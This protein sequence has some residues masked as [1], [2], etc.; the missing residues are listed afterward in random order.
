MEL[1]NKT[2]Y[3]LLIIGLFHFLAMSANTNILKSGLSQNR[4]KLNLKIKKVEQV[5]RVTGTP[6]QGDN[7][8]SPNNTT[9]MYDVGGTDLG[10]VWEMEKG[11][12]GIFMGDTYGKGFIPDQDDPATFGDNWR[13]NVLAFSKD[14]DLRDGITI[15]AMSVDEKGYAQELIPGGKDKSGNGDWTSIP[16]AA[17]RANNI[18]YVHYFNMKNWTGWVTN[19]SGLYKSTDN[20]QTW[21]ECPD[22]YFTSDSNFGQ[23]G[24]FKK[25]GYVYMVGTET[26]R[27]SN[28]RLVRFKEKDI[29]KQYLYE[30]WNKDKNKWIR[31]DESEATNLFEDTVGEL[32][33]AYNTKYKCWIMAYFCGKRYEISL[34]CA[35]ELTGE[36]SEPLTLATGRQY[37]QLY[38]SFIHP[39]SL[40]GDE[41]YFL[42]SMWRPYNIFLMK[43]ELTTEN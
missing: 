34:R 13:C 10:I 6:V 26:G 18:D 41:L 42:M 21:S 39:A 3:S 19:Y 11:K 12:Y 33:I 24:Y 5:A 9:D 36:W 20:G 14:N 23:A 7:L 27:K 4:K 28:P 1:K 15:D 31:G 8:P 29:E 38:G 40:D 37:S 43:A 2:G 32:S 22:V 17:I 35:T 30:Y 16:T 25:D